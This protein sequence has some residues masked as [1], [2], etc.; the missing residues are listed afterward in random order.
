MWNLALAFLVAFSFPVA[1]ESPS[2][3]VSSIQGNWH[4][5]GN[6]HHG[7]LFIQVSNDGEVSGKIYD[8][9]I[10]GSW[11]SKDNR[12]VFTR[13]RD[14][15][16][17][18]EWKGELQVDT[19]N[20]LA[21]AKLLGTFRSLAG[22]EFGA[23]DQVYEW[24]GIRLG[25]DG[26]YVGMDA[27]TSIVAQFVTGPFGERSLCPVLYKRE[28][29]KVAVFARDFNT[30]VGSL[31]K[32]VDKVVATSQMDDV[33]FVFISH[34][35]DPTPSEMEF[36]VQLETM[37]KFAEQEMIDHLSLGTMIRIPDKTVSTRALKKLGFFGDGE[38]VVMVISPGPRKNRGVVRYFRVLKAGVSEEEIKELS[39]ELTEALAIETKR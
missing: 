4:I 20:P 38:S 9:P 22:P 26:L 31:V 5:L 34:E 18:Q 21:P 8:E 12:L 35:N 32:A 29:L 2:T 7:S 19:A 33:S 28:S 11:D 24:S 30:E 3:P 39:I 13:F 37:K 10:K 27:P 1:D 25:K 17:I 23:A 16:G 6:E 36:Q 15:I 14:E